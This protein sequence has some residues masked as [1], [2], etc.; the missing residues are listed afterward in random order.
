[1]RHRPPPHSPRLTPTYRLPSVVHATD[2]C[3]D[4]M[5][6]LVASAL[7]RQF[8]GLS[9]TRTAAVVRTAGRE[10]WN[11]S[12]STVSAGSVGSV[13]VLRQVLPYVRMRSSFPLTLSP[14]R[15]PVS[16]SP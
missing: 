5:P 16:D 10:P 4:P 1:M 7:R 6:V 2:G 12:A 11:P 9:S 13:A 15:T 3:N 8:P 14:P